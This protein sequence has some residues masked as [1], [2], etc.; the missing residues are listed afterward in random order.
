MVN[1]SSTPSSNLYH[2]DATTSKISLIMSD[3]H[4]SNPLD[5]LQNLSQDEC[6]EL[7]I[8]AIRNTGKTAQGHGVLSLRKAATIYQVTRQ[9][10]ANR[11]LERCIWLLSA[12][13]VIARLTA[14]MWHDCDRGQLPSLD[15]FLD[16]HSKNIRRDVVWD[17]K[18]L[19]LT[20]ID[21]QDT[22]LSHTW[23]Y[24]RKGSLIVR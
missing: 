23:P 12:S 8:I 6:I 1:L 18:I 15:T 20:G 3:I 14:N 4:I 11:I 2:A 22:F 21:S 7:A 10:L 9:T 19:I 24:L 16:L 13:A 17:S 5:D